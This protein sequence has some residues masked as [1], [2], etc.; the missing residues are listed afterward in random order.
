MMF[1][2]MISDLH[3]LGEFPLEKSRHANR[4]YRRGLPQWPQTHAPARG[5]FRRDPAK[6]GPWQDAI[7]QDCQRQQGPG[8]HCLQGS[9]V[10]VH[11]CRGNCRWQREND[12]GYDLDHHSAFRYSRH[13]RRGDDC[14]R[15]SAFVVSAQNGS[16]QER[17]CAKLSSQVSKIF[18]DSDAK[19]SRQIL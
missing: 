15:R 6:A 14:Q 1:C 16:L 19:L 2:M 4:E 18:L 8:F 10:G 9:Q 11:W 12:S 7:S 3:G 13:F 17:Q 5:H